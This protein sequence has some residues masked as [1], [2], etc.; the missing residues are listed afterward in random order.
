V[1]FIEIEIRNERFLIEQNI[2]FTKVLMTENILSHH[3]FDATQSIYC[4]LKEEGIHDFD[5]QGCGEKAF[6]CVHLLTFKRDV[7]INTSVYKTAKRGDKRMWLGADNFSV[8]LPNDIYLMIA[9]AGELYILNM[10]RIDILSCCTTEIDNP[11][12]KFMNNYF[13]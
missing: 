3:I 7:N 13:K 2:L 5:S 10:S 11:I 6:I 1:V 12:K 9:K 8:T 4:F